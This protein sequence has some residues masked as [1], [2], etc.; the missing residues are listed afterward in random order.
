MSP[1]KVEDLVALGFNPEKQNWTGHGHY[2]GSRR[3]ID[4]SQGE[5]LKAEPEVLAFELTPLVDDGKHWRILT[6]GVVEREAIDPSLADLYDVTLCSRAPTHRC[7]HGIPCYLKV[8]AKKSYW[9][10]IDA[11]LTEFVAKLSRMLVSL[12]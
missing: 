2:V 6:D 7:A 5:Q 3:I 4:G 12:R 10:F 9:Y 1:F 11:A 8:V